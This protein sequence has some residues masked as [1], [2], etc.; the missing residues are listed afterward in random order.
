MNR[1]LRI[2]ALAVLAI[3]LSGAALAG[4]TRQDAGF[5]HERH[6]GFFPDCTGCH[7]GIVEEGQPLWPSVEDLCSACHDGDTRA[8]VKWKPREGPRPTNLKFT[9]S[10]HSFALEECGMCHVESED[11]ADRMNVQRAV[12]SRC[13]TCHE[14]EGTHPALPD[15]SCGL[16]HVPLT[17]ARLLSRQAVASFPKP[18]THEVPGFVEGGHGKLAQSGETAIAASCA[19]CHARNQCITCHVNAPELA[20]IQALGE[21]ERA[22]VLTDVIPLPASHEDPDWN[23]T[24]SSVARKGSAT[25]AT[26]HTQESCRTCHS[27]MANRAVDALPEPGPGRGSGVQLTRTP[28][29]SHTWEFRDRHGPS[30]SASPATCETCHVR[31]NCLSCHR[32]DAASSGSYHP[33]GFLTKHPASAWNRDANCSDCHNPAQFCQTCHKQAGLISGVGGIG[34][35]GYHDAFAGFLVGH[36]P[37]ARQNLESCA[38]CHKE[39]DCT[40]CHAG[41]GIGYGFNPHGSGFNAERLKKKNPSLCYAC[42]GQAIPGGR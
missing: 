9:H 24:H 16:C 35:R 2:A 32:P 33:N 38:S 1:V 42:H 18:G 31:E 37:S 10:V 12:V 19:T 14:I 29:T 23:R 22:P 41:S 8:A 40:R 21:D 7:A 28:P 36:G 17:E 3:G 25:C 26:C 5:P 34:K 20:P 15:T 6:Q 13:Q 30:A 27:G 39:S 4:L 11:P